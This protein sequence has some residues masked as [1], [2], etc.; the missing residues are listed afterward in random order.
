MTEEQWFAAS[1]ADVR[2]AVWSLTPR[3]QRL[4]A[5][6]VCR[7]LY[8]GFDFSGVQAALDAAE[9]FADTLK[10]KAALRRGRQ[11]VEADRVSL[12]TDPQFVTNRGSVERALFAA[13]MAASENAVVGTVWDALTCVMFL[14]DLSEEQAR[15]LLARGFLDVAG[16]DPLP[17]FS[18]KWR[19]ETAVLL[20]RQMYESRDFSAMPILA[21]ALQDA[22]CDNDDILNH[23][24]AEAVHVRGCWVVDLVIGKT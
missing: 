23:C 21:D 12:V 18:P 3:R 20:A 6:A 4:L 7:A 10:T 24:R 14:H 11:A 17:S 1:E 5:V 15:G 19:T 22:G 16:P 13:K 2:A 8:D 9:V